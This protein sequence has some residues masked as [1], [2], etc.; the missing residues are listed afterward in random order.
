MQKATNELL[1][2]AKNAVVEHR[3]SQKEKVEIKNR[4]DARCFSLLADQM[5]LCHEKNK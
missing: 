1:C 5:L 3:M 2:I 4:N